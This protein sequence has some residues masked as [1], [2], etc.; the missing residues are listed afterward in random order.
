MNSLIFYNTKKIQIYNYFNHCHCNF[1]FSNFTQKAIDFE[2]IFRWNTLWVRIAFK[3]FWIKIV[4]I[5]ALI[6]STLTDFSPASTKGTIFEKR[7]T[8]GKQ[9]NWH[10]V[11]VQLKMCIGNIYPHYIVSYFFHNTYK[12]IL[13]L[14]LMQCTHQLKKFLHI[15]NRSYRMLWIF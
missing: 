5:S 10:F 6:F 13:P 8:D 11:I 7:K 1:L 9:T 14:A 2:S 12:F 4:Q 15:L 3:I